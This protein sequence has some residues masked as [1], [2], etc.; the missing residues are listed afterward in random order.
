MDPLAAAEAPS[1][2]MDTHKSTAAENLRQLADTTDVPDEPK[3]VEIPAV[4]AEQNGP[5]EAVTAD[6][7]EPREIVMA[8]PEHGPEEPVAADVPNGTGL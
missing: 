3:E 7:N 5:S 6:P 8:A 2:V 4:G 1:E